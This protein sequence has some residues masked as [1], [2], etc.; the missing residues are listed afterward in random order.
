[1]TQDVGIRDVHI[2][3]CDTLAGGLKMGVDEN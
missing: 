2:D 3:V 1:M